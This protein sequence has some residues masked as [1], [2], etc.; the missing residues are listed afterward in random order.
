LLDECLELI[1]IS[2]K[3]PD[4]SII[5]QYM[6]NSSKSSRGT[7]S[8]RYMINVTKKYTLFVN[9]LQKDLKEIDE[10]YADSINNQLNTRLIKQIDD[11]FCLERF[12]VIPIQVSKIA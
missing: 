12:K 6:A 7:T 4:K 5:K 9:E 3:R 8:D 2:F 11:L 1:F 10:Q